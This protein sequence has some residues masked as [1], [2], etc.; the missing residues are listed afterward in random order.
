MK[1]LFLHKKIL[2]CSAASVV[3][4]DF[5]VVTE[6]FDG[7]VAFHLVG[8]AHTLLGGTVDGGEFDFWVI[9]VFVGGSREFRFGFFAVATP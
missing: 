5:R 7:G 2:N 4:D 8:T 1:T 9:F 3:S 6:V